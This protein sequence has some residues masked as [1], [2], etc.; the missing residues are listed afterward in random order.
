MRRSLLP[1]LVGER[2]ESVDV[3]DN[4]LR[5]PVRKDRLRELV[6]G[7]A[8]RCL[9]RRA[10]YLLVE[11]EGGSTLA[12][13][14]GMS[15]RLTLT[16]AAAPREKHEHVSFQLASGRRLRFRDPRRFGLV[17]AL[18]SGAVDED[19]HFRHLGQEPLTQRFDGVDLQA[20]ASRRHGP[21]KNFLMNA[22]VV[23]GVG[24]IYACEALHEA[25]VHPRRS[26]ARISPGSWA[27]I[28]AAVK[29]VLGAAIEQGGTT[30]NDFTN[31]DGEAGYFQ[32]SLRVYGRAG[33]SCGRCGRTIRRIVQA[34]RSSFYCLGCQR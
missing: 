10:K 11:M 14:L 4:R 22:Q 25:R 31:G 7:R 30:L 34:G 26:V 33:E 21:V 12:I 13:H 32:V 15:G 18:P 16:S 9:G 23:V 8:I 20:A 6:E 3:A 2:V 28:A 27:R 29:S 1:H 5:E 19:R 17:F 24:N